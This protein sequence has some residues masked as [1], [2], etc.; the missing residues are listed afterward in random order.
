MKLLDPDISYRALH[1]SVCRLSNAM[2]TLGVKKGDRVTIYLPMIP[3]LPVALLACARLG[4]T[5]SVVFGGFSAKPKRVTGPTFLP[6][7]WHCWKIRIWFPQAGQN[8]AS[9]GTGPL[10]PGQAA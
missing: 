9:A 3:E 2:K 5:H 6:Q 7:E 1:D 8:R 4:I 10:Q